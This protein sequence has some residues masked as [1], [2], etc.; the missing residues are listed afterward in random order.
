MAST[1][2]S[3]VA[4]KES[5]LD[6]V[7]CPLANQFIHPPQISFYSPPKKTHLMTKKFGNMLPVDANKPDE[8]LAVLF[9]SNQ[10]ESLV[11]VTSRY[12]YTGTVHVSETLVCKLHKQ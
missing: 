5:V 8:E 2:V 4:C 11:I 1:H 12:W 7:P 9:K 3:Y 6:Q 10:T